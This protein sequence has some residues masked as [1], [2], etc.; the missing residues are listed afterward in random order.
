MS[1]LKTLILCLTFLQSQIVAQFLYSR[2]TF[3]DADMQASFVIRN[4]EL[5]DCEFPCLPTGVNGTRRFIQYAIIL[6]NTGNTSAVFIPYHQDPIRI[7]YNL[8]NS[9]MDNIKSGYYNLSCVR[10]SRCSENWEKMN[11]FYCGYSGLTPGCKTI[12]SH[13]EVCQWVDITGL[14]EF[15]QYNLSL[16]LLPGVLGQ[17][18]DQLDLTVH[19]FTIIPGALPSGELYTTKRLL[20]VE[21]LILGPVFIF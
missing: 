20:V 11:Y 9:S 5:F 17:G 6:E 7:V 10:D 1:R 15:S 4:R 21:T 14:E 2:V 12:I 19:N 16:S 13:Q 3:N 8:S 18:I